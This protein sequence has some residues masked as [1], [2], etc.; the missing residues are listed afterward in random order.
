MKNRVTALLLAMLLC[1]TSGERE[2]F[3]S[4]APLFLGQEEPPRTE[5]VPVMPAEEEP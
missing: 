4:L 5:Q 2:R 3:E 1:L